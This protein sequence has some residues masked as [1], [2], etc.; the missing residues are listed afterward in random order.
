MGRANGS[1]VRSHKRNRA[2]KNDPRLRPWYVLAKMNP[3]K[4]FVIKPLK[5]LDVGTD[6]ISR[7][8]K[9]DYRI[10]IQT[11]DEIE[12]IEFH[13]EEV[14]DNMANMV[15]AK[16]REKLLEILVPLSLMPYLGWRRRKLKKEASWQAP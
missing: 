7:T 8:G 1:F 12:H 9:L 4:M 15:P 3:G 6:V 14:L 16:A 10:D 13:L 5:K 2:T 11:G